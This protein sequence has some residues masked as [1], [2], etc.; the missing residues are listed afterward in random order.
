M[1]IPEIE[2]QPFDK[3]KSYQ[4]SRLQDAL[5]YL[6]ATSPFYQRHFQQSKIVV[7]K[8]KS[9]D[10]LKYIPP[11]TKDDFAKHND[12]FRCVAN[13]KFIDLTSTSGTTGKPVIVGL[14]EKDLQRLAYNEYISFCCAGASNDDVFQLMVTLDRQF[15]AGTAYYLGVRKLGASMIRTGPGMPWMQLETLQRMKPTVLVAVPS[16]LLK[17]IDFAKAHNFDLQNSSVKK[18]ICI[19]EN[20]RQPNFEFNNLGKRIK[21]QWNVQLFSTYASTEMQTAF[22][23]C[24]AGKGG[25]HHPELIIVELLDE[26]NNPVQPGES[27]EVTITSLGIEGMPVLRYKTGD[28]SA[29]HHEACSCGRK[30]LRLGPVIGR[31][32]HMLKYKGT[33]LYPSIIN[34]ILSGT[35]D[36]IDFAV[37]A[38]TSD[39]GTDELTFHINTTINDAE[40]H[41]RIKG[42]LQSK[43]R[44][45]PEIK[46]IDQNQLLAIL[47]PEKNRKVQRFIDNRE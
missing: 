15:M 45:L 29:N 5:A 40:G 25:H 26:E 16:F 43:L 47:N 31:K 3:I 35:S 9:L 19:G 4:A 23:E 17:L 46:F 28:I 24:E 20:I 14:T 1:F 27:G 13:N 39:A 2:L 38:K 30:T 6:S 44:V 36:I 21:E 7:S 42:Y 32:N 8:V 12:E 37:E 33:T 22:S 11:V 41:A 34:D 10:D 18:V